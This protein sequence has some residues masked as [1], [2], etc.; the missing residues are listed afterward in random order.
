MPRLNGCHG[1]PWPAMATLTFLPS[2]QRRACAFALQLTLTGVLGR[3]AFGVVYKVR[4]SEGSARAHGRKVMFL[5]EQG[6]G[7]GGP[8]PVTLLQPVMYPRQGTVTASVSCRAA[9]TH[10]HAQTCPSYLIMYPAVDLV[11]HC[12]R[13]SGGTLTAP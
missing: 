9:I 8:I 11:A 5:S 3:G 1:Q 13:A 2:S 12:C 7:V 6:L 4:R 10:T